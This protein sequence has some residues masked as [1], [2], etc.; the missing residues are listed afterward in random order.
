MEMEGGRRLGCRMGGCSTLEISPFPNGATGYASCQ[1][2]G[3]IQVCCR[4]PNEYR[5]S[6]SRRGGK[7][8]RC[9]NH[10]PCYFSGAR[11]VGVMM[12]T[13]IAGAGSVVGLAMAAPM[14]MRAVLSCSVSW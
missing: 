5:V 12:V 4:I 7:A 14:L 9:S 10:A 1:V 2:T 11:R 8:Q 13:R 3:L 6:R